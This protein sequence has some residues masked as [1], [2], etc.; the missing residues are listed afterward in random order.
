MLK[1][2]QRLVKKIPNNNLLGTKVGD[3]YEWMSVRETAEMSEFIGLGFKGFELIPETEAEDKKWKFMGIQSK[4]RKEWQLCYFGSMYQSATVV[5][6][7]DTLGQ[8]GIKFVVKETELASMCVAKDQVK[9]LATLKK[10][11]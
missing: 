5:G 6:L 4:N 7:Y 1:G 8:D 11:D 3:K 9:N 10:A 2:L